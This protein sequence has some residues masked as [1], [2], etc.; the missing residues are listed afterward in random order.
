MSKKSDTSASIITFPRP[1]I[2][3][4]SRKNVQLF[5]GLM[6]CENCQKN[7]I[8]AN[9]SLFSNDREIEAESKAQN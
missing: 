2:L 1:C 8:F 7:I 4:E 3:C 6:V 5:A 9:P